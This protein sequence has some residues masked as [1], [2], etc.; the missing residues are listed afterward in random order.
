M[1]PETARLHIQFHGRVIEHLGID[2]YQSPVAAIAELVSNAWDADATK[3]EI[4][5]PMNVRA[6]SEILI[7][8]NGD[9]MT[10]AQCQD[11]YL[12]VGYNRRIEQQAEKTSGGRPVMGRK[13]IG[14]FAGFGIANLV[15]V[16]TVSRETGERTV[17]RLDVEKLTGSGAEYADNTPMEVEVLE[18][19]GPDEER[20]P[21]HGTRIRLQQLTMKKT[22]NS[23]QFRVSM[24]RRFLLLERAEDFSVTVD[25][26]PI[27]EEGDS[28]RIE[29]DYPSD[30]D[31][32][33]R[34]AG[35]EI[36]DG[37]GVESLPNGAEIRWRFVFYSDPIQEEDLAGISIFS[38]HKLSQRPFTF[39]LSG[40]FGA[41]HAIN[42]LSG[43]VQADYIDD[44]DKD[45]ISTERQRINWEADQ[46]LPLLAWGQERTKSL[47]R[48]WQ[49]RRAEAKVSAM[50]LRMA[51]FS[52]RLDKLEPYEA[53][54]VQRA[55]TA[56]ARVSVLSDAQFDDLANAILSAWEG[57][58]LREL[59]NELSNAAELDAE[60]LVGILAKSRVMTALH[61]AERVRSQLNLING[62]EER[63]NEKRL[64]NAVR[65]YIA[66]NP[67]MISPEW[68]TFRVERGLSNL[69][70]E[71]S[72]ETLDKEE[73]WNARVDLVLSSGDQLLVLE[74][75]RPGK[76]ADWDHVY[77]FERY[78]E[79][80]R[81]VVDVRRSEFR[82]VTG[83]MVA[84]KLERPAGFARKL[85]RLRRDGMDATDWAGLLEK[86]KKQWQDYFDI[87]YARAPEDERMQALISGGS[88]DNETGEDEPSDS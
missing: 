40:G 58:R 54:I 14:K 28:E 70:E 49:N 6:G 74:F 12:K 87:L 55:L 30:Y 72:K 50:N 63:I 27:A 15:D 81:D 24:A 52:N 75:M 68:E 25:G 47:L 38:H 3:V 34:P 42:Y 2:M 44:Q 23:D 77:R 61:A 79:S 65:D 76:T 64:E 53:K 66:Q 84:D 73:A 78:I 20:K 33:Q 35:L 59:I 21:Q 18:Y 62:L 60:E 45:L 48:I 22:P 80:L 31:G 4:S 16:E 56:V 29:F 11:R 85:D 71:I 7:S 46:A 9:G 83:L 37:W 41:Q 5:L 82:S 26:T 8:D 32:K 57:G 86:A 88:N 1:A 51:P 13:G 19:S 67:W 17:F 69:M 43:R 10:L 36:E 39:N